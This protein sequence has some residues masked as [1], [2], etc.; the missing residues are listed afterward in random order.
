MGPNR[1]FHHLLLTYPSS[2]ISESTE[3]KVDGWRRQEKIE[4][5]INY[6]GVLAAKVRKRTS[7]AELPCKSRIWGLTKNFHET[8]PGQFHMDS[9]RSL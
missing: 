9:F 5:Y 1:V 4:D 8:F 2:F 7:D 3:N 6:L